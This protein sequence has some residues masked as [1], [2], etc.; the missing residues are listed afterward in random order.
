MKLPMLKPY[1]ASKAAKG[2]FD[3][4]TALANKHGLYLPYYFAVD[5]QRLEQRVIALL[6]Q[7]EAT[8]AA[9]KKRKRK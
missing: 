4:A 7:T 5:L 2:F 6:E 3:R 1:Y 9:K 8:V